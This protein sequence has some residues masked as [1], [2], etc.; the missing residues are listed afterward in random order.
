MSGGGTKGAAKAPEMRGAGTADDAFDARV[1][2]AHTN[3][4]PDP[5]PG[6]MAEH[7]LTS[8]YS[9][10]PQR[11]RAGGTL[12]VRMIEV[13]QDAVET[14]DPPVPEI[15][16]VGFASGSEA[17]GETDFG[18][19]WRSHT[20]PQGSVDP[21]PAFTECRFRVP[22][23]HLL[24]MT[25]DHATLSA[26]LDEVGASVR[27]FD[28]LAN[29]VEPMPHAL[30]LLQRAWAAM[31]RAGAAANLEVDA[32]VTGLVAAM[33]ARAEALPAPP[34]Q[35]G[36]RRLARVID[37]VEAH[38]PEPMTAGELAGVAHV[39]LFHFTRIFR[40]ATGRTPG[41]YVA[42][43]RVERAKAMLHAPHGGHAGDPP[44]LAEIAFACGFASQSHFGQVFKAHTGAT[45]GQWREG[46]AG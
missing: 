23:F 42:H 29:T 33:L 21:Q 14:I 11:H 16:F 28:A 22:A 44:S 31:G 38:L 34:P 7:Y 40:E 18:D 5:A 8:P 43:R 2:A 37:Y 35:I 46:A 32:A 36:D 24:G 9:R 20:W 41:A 45:P 26:R 4:A 39:S 15:A 1:D 12:G 25:I 3:G 30:A 10:F 13:E 27:T 17:T 6:T 19:G